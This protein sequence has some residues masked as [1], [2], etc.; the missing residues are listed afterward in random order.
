MPDEDAA[1]IHELGK[2][3]KE[4]IQKFYKKHKRKLKMEIEHG[5]FIVCN[6]GYVVT[7]VIDKKNTA[8]SNFI[9]CDGGMELNA[10]PLF[11]GSR[12]PMY[13]VAADG[14]HVMSSEFREIEGDYEAV[15]AGKC[16][17]NGD[18]QTLDKAGKTITRKMAEP[19]IGDIAIIGGVGAYC[20][21]MAPFNYNSHPQVPEVLFTRTGDLKLVRKRQT[22]EQVLENEI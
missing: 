5:T 15:V 4:Q 14:S 1:D 8:V 9:L 6:A 10:R 18:C 7:K 3:A 17:E 12:H 11:Y 13:I 19:E 20:S 16:C 21:S 22:L 2:Y